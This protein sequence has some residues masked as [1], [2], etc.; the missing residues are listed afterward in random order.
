MNTLFLKRETFARVVFLIAGIYGFAVL[1]PQY[2][3]EDLIARNYPP[4]LT[5]PEQFY[6]FLGLA[7]AWQCASTALWQAAP[8]SKT[9]AP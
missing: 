9:A 2:F 7:M 5:H 6:G 1:V 4:P 8:E 3:M